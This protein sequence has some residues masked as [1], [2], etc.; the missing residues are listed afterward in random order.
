VPPAAGVGYSGGMSFKTFLCLLVLAGLAVA[1]PFG[2]GVKL[3]APLTDAFQ[4]QSFSSLST[5]TASSSHFTVGPYVEVRLPL[6]FALEVDALH[7]GYNYR[8]AVGSTSNSDWEFPVLAKYKLLKGPI[9]PYVSGGLSFSKLSDV[10]RINNL[11]G[12]NHGNSYG[13][14]LG[15]GIEV[16]TPAVRISGELR[17]TGWTFLTFG[18]GSVLRTNRNQ[19]ALLFGIGF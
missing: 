11:V 12:V 7:R 17:Y 13:I 2:V 5:F 19:A 18:S 16:K 10:A 4:Q 3:G 6:N 15:G 1:Q 9:K 8:N 14:V